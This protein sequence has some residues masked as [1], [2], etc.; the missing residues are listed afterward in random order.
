MTDAQLPATTGGTNL[1]TLLVGAEDDFVSMRKKDILLPRAT[2]LQANSPD[3]ASGRFPSGTVMDSATK[4]EIIKA[5]TDGKFII[6]LMMWLEWIEWNPKRN[7]PK[8]E[9]IIDRSVD[10]SGKLA[11]RADKWETITNAE[12]REVCVVTEYYNYIGIILDPKMNDYDSVYLTGFCRSSHRIGKMWLNRLAKARM[13]IEPGNWVKAP[14][15]A[16]RWAYKTEMVSK[17]GYTYYVPS[18]G[19]GQLNPQ[20]DWAML[21]GVSDGFKARRSEIMDRNSNKDD[22]TEAAAGATP[23]SAANSEM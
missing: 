1:S 5:R 10:P 3:V 11:N 4:S 8:D 7:A 21:K 12:G 20:A 22:E 14:M 19:E 16:Y 15:W 2:I 17:D 18:I 6:P 9:K 13:E 23:V